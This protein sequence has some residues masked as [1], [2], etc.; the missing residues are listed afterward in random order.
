MVYCPY[1]AT[2][3]MSQ[4]AETVLTRAFVFDLVCPT[5]TAG[6]IYRTHAVRDGRSKVDS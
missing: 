2:G 3:H 6:C 5:H 4:H 1:G